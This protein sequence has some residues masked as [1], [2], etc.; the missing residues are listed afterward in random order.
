[1]SW[2]KKRTQEKE[3]WKRKNK[4]HDM[5]TKWGKNKT[6]YKD[7]CEGKRGGE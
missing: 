6:Q 1:M 5:N 3:K 2:R 7:E 4:R